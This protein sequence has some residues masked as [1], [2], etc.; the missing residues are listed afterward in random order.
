MTCLP[1]GGVRVTMWRFF[2]ATLYS[3]EGLGNPSY[4]TKRAKLWER[5]FESTSVNT[6]ARYT[7]LANLEIL[8]GG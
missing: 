3:S 7:E 6:D 2:D 1:E 8:V 5:T 4:V